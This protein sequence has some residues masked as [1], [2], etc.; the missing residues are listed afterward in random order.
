MTVCAGTGALWTSIFF[1][2]TILSRKFFTESVDIACR[3]MF[4]W[5]MAKIGP[6]S[7]KMLM[8]P[9]LYSYTSV[10]TVVVSSC[11]ISLHVT[12]IRPSHTCLAALVPDCG[13]WHVPA[14]QRQ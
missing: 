5:S 11:L 13:G 6:L 8:Y 7:R 12:L 14:V 1:Y 4:D 2:R 10:K 9:H 3:Q